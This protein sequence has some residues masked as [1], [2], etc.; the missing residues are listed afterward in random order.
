MQI[1]SAILSGRKISEAK[2]CSVATA[3]N[4]LDTRHATIFWK[5]ELF[6]HQELGGSERMSGLSKKESARQT[7]LSLAQHA[8]AADHAVV[9]LLTCLL[10]LHFAVNLIVPLFSPLRLL[11]P[12]FCHSNRGLLSGA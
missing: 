12:S 1:N 4:I 5:A 3:G 2:N 7:A 10:A 9:T 6:F 11:A 8:V